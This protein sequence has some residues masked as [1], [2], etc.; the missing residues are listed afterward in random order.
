MAAMGLLEPGEALSPERENLRIV[1]VRED[2]LEDGYA[3]A[4]AE[5][6]ISRQELK[7]L[8]G[9]EF[10]SAKPRILFR[11][12]HLALQIRSR[13]D[14]SQSTALAFA[15]TQR[16]TSWY[17]GILGRLL[18][19]LGDT[20][21][22]VGHFHAGLSAEE[23]ESIYSR[24]KDPADPLKILVCTKAFGMGMDIPNIHLL[25]HLDCP[26]ALEDYLQEIG[27]AGR[28]PR[29]LR[30]LG[31]N[32]ANPIP[33]LFYFSQ[34]EFEEARNFLRKG[35]LAFP[36]LS[37]YMQLLRAY[38]GQ[39]ARPGGGEQGQRKFV[40]NLNYIESVKGK[41]WGDVRQSMAFHWLERLNR[42]ELGYYVLPVIGILE[43][44]PAPPTE[45]TPLARLHA[46]LL[47]QKAALRSSTRESAQ[48]H[49]RT[50][51]LLRICGSMDALY[52]CL[53][54][55][56]R[57]GLFRV[58]QRVHME[59]Q[60]NQ[61]AQALRSEAETRL[62]EGKLPWLLELRF[63]FVLQR[64]RGMSVSQEFQVTR[65]ELQ[66]QL[67]RFA[68]EESEAVTADWMTDASATRLQERQASWLQQ[69]TRLFVSR[70]GPL[71]R[72]FRAF[73]GCRIRTGFDPVY[74]IG[75]SF[76]LQ[77][78]GV[79][80]Q[81]SRLRDLCVEL[82]RDLLHPGK[83]PLELVDWLNKL[84][85]KQ[86]EL[87][88]AVGFLHRCDLLEQ[89]SLFA[90]AI[91][92]KFLSDRRIEGEKEPDRTVAA[93]FEENAR[94]KECRLSALELLAWLKSDGERRELVEAYFKAGNA[95]EIVILLD[96][97]VAQGNWS[98][99]EDPQ[100]KKILSVL[101]EQG[102]EDHHG[103]LNKEQR[104]I[105]EAGPDC[106]GVV[107]AGPG[108]GKTR[109]IMERAVWLVEK[110]NVDP[111]Q[112]LLLA[113]NRA[114]R[115]ELQ[116]RLKAYYKELGLQ[117]YIEKLRVNTIHGFARRIC[118]DRVTYCSPEEVAELLR[119]IDQKYPRWID[120][121]QSMN[122]LHSRDT[123]DPKF[124][125]TVRQGDGSAPQRGWKLPLELWIPLATK[126]LSETPQRNT[127]TV[128]MIDEIQDL[129]GPMIRLLAALLKNPAVRLVAVG[130]P[131]QSI[132]G[133]ERK[134]H[135][136][137][138]APEPMLEQL[139]QRLAK[140]GG[141][142]PER[143]LRQNYR[144]L[145]AILHEAQKMRPNPYRLQATRT[146]AE[147]LPVGIKPVQ[148]VSQKAG[149]VCDHL[150]RLLD[151]KAKR[152]G[153]LSHW[154]S[155]A[156]LC[157]TNQEQDNILRQLRGDDRL[158]NLKQM[159]RV[160]LY[161]DHLLQHAAQ[162]REFRAMK[163]AIR[164]LPA[165]FS[166]EELNT[167]LRTVL[168]KGRGILSGYLLQQGRHLL[169]DLAR[170]FR[171]EVEQEDLL[172]EF[173]DHAREKE[174]L[175]ETLGRIRQAQHADSVTITVGTIHRSKGLEY[176]V[177]LLPSSELNLPGDEEELEEERRLRY[178]A[179]T[180]ARTHVLQII[181]DRETALQEGRG[182]H[183]KFSPR[184]P[185]I[186][187]GQDLFFQSCLLEPDWRASG[188][189][190]LREHQDCLHH[191][192]PDKAPLQR[193]GRHFVYMD[194]ER[195]REVIVCRCSKAYME[196]IDSWR[197]GREQEAIRQDYRVSAV[198]WQEVDE[199]FV[200]QRSQYAAIPAD[201]R[202]VGGFWWVVVEGGEE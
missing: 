142:L 42:I 71:F 46:F 180:R 24:F 22:Q 70:Q 7:D 175:V 152:K 15:R 164:P 25:A 95:E 96:R 3:K 68:E 8:V 145:G 159:G 4:G 143:L 192:L 35:R 113:Y 39:F 191:T 11:L 5:H 43:L 108:S 102:L 38:R 78:P 144:S 136:N 60:R 106:C 115:I 84:E 19:S 74:G 18:H 34:R 10:A 17:A 52:E 182:W 32:A 131:D 12:Y 103:R 59:L 92:I 155:F 87:E 129:T 83:E 147:L 100:V 111:S 121:W 124:A 151:E 188:M 21:M 94:L 61:G 134:R 81:V 199:V 63:Q 195:K 126:L 141:E 133:Y 29:L 118:G 171:D 149:T 177:V 112:I 80:Q 163:E 157:R 27:R 79:V 140:Q 197:K 196:R 47:E 2:R 99:E 190:S 62:E 44:Q 186:R 184:P 135:G 56:R 36:Q 77:H 138:L 127:R 173:E 28:D 16:N 49:V 45:D 139:E 110:H 89:S 120:D 148:S 98:D 26:A 30:N 114:V 119:Y 172:N 150:F 181:G 20:E 82:L 50:S 161:S 14:P 198:L 162:S 33:C 179:I 97:L 41:D 146:Q 90:G 156:V 54:E 183:G 55:G 170:S 137:P 109:V 202:E 93:D 201:V 167:A 64:L 176:D 122:L 104:A 9:E 65:G 73:E 174:A 53:K 132:Y 130:D 189:N 72:L 31:L 23:R 66:E 168:S 194:R 13:L 105:V 107:R 160:Q 158:R 6:A 88:T 178:V 128:L 58:S 40:Y 101:K 193:K 125:T 1:P 57:L 76:E 187:D 154:R 200:E 116:R 169:L 51:D 67:Q 166:V 69:T 165:R 86:E 185:A 85:C 91:E 123:L 48:L 153:K 37:D 117:G 75:Y